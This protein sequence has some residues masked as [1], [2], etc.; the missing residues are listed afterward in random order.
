MACHDPC[1]R[2]IVGAGVLYT[3][4]RRDRNPAS[5]LLWRTA[6]HPSPRLWTR[7]WAPAVV[8]QVDRRWRDEDGIHPGWI[9][10]GN[11]R[12]RWHRAFGTQSRGQPGEEL[13]QEVRIAPSLP[14]SH[15][16][17]HR[18]P[19]VRHCPPPPSRPG[20]SC[21]PKASRAL[22]RST[23]A[24]TLARVRQK[25]RRNQP[26]ASRSATCATTPTQRGQIS[27]ISMAQTSMMRMFSGTPILVKSVKR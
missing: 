17:A 1:L 24:P 4:D 7:C 12:R 18:V 20:R 13:T 3:S 10:N 14:H 27:G 15:I 8:A 21:H 23:A 2:S 26:K 19:D 25:A 6:S 11:L 5:M 9:G 16:L 22:F